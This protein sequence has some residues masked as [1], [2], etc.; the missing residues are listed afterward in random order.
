MQKSTAEYSEV[1]STL[2]LIEFIITLLLRSWLT[3]AAWF[4]HHKNSV[5]LKKLPKNATLYVG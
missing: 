5:K 2:Y 4:L 1:M 3:S